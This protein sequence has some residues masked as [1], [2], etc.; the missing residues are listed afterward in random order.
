MEQHGN[1]TGNNTNTNQV[2][3]TLSQFDT[4]ASHEVLY[5]EGAS[6]VAAKAFIEDSNLNSATL[7]AVVTVNAEDG[8]SID[9]PVVMTWTG[10]S[11]IQQDPA[12]IRVPGSSAKIPTNQASRDAAATGSVTFQGTNLTPGD[13][14][15]ARLER[16]RDTQ[17]P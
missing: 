2:H 4:C 7:S 9:V 11:G 16:V 12:E 3:L 6:D 1:A 14:T 13:A 17:G 8:T 5:A 15:F 10:Q